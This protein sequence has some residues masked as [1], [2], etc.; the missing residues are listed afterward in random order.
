MRARGKKSRNPELQALK[1]CF[2]MP[3]RDAMRIIPTVF[4][5]IGMRLGRGS[6]NLTFCISILLRIAFSVQRDWSVPKNGT[7]IHRGLSFRVIAK[8]IH[9]K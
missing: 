2:K 5:A 8:S 7:E 6:Y 3:V 9:F 1:L 4:S